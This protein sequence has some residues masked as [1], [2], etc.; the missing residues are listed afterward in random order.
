MATSISPEDVRRLLKYEDLIP[1][2]E[3]C[4][5][6]FSKHENSGVVQPVRS[7]VNV[8][9]GKG[10]CWSKVLTYILYTVNCG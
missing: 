8:N 1:L 10:Y 4:L 7:V 2:I 9:D 6:N 5:A 3:N